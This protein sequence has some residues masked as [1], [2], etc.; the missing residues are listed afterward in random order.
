M[1]CS[2]PWTP[3]LHPGGH[4]GPHSHKVCGCD[5]TLGQGPAGRF[6]GVPSGGRCLASP[7]SSREACSRGRKGRL[8]SVP[9]P[10]ATPTRLCQVLGD[11]SAPPSRQPRLGLSPCHL[12]AG[13]KPFA[14]VGE[15]Q[16]WKKSEQLADGESWGTRGGSACPSSHRPQ[17]HRRDTVLSQNLRDF[18]Q[19]CPCCAR[20]PGSAGFSHTMEQSARASPRAMANTE[21]LHP[22]ALWGNPKT[23][24]KLAQLRVRRGQQAVSKDRHK[25]S[26]LQTALLGCSEPGTVAWGPHRAMHTGLQSLTPKGRSGWSLHSPCP[27]PG[28]QG[29]PPA[30]RSRAMTANPSPPTYPRPP[31][32]VPSAPQHEAAGKGST[33]RGCPERVGALGQK[34]V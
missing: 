6:E 24:S 18:W 4:L 12:Q 30:P 19:P 33:P 10:E 1:A 13:L 29:E 7:L 9:T 11:C 21:F 23:Q 34:W 27:A 20:C 3:V 17:H 22:L 14:A 2:D 16:V 8:A 25:H 28:W 15:R 31:P 32:A 26:G 5:P